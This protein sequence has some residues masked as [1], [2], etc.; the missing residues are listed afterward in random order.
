MATHSRNFF[1][2]YIAPFL[3]LLAMTSFLWFPGLRWYVTVGRHMDEV[4]QFIVADQSAQALALMHNLQR[5]HPHNARLLYLVAGI[6]MQMGRTFAAETVLY[7]YARAAADDSYER[8]SDRYTRAL[9]YIDS[10][11]ASHVKAAAD[12]T[13]GITRQEQSL[14]DAMTLLNKTIDLNNQSPPSWRKQVRDYKFADILS[15]PAVGPYDELGLIVPDKLFESGIVCSDHKKCISAY[16]NASLIDSVAADRLAIDASAIEPGCCAVSLDDPDLRP[17]DDIMA[18]AMVHHE[19]GNTR[20][21]NDEAATLS[22]TLG[23]YSRVALKH[24]FVAD[25]LKLAQ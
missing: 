3:M 16:G 9:H 25:F 2:N 8:Q 6:Y 13:L 20:G 1:G 23:I 15:A 12:P 7:A 10:F 5:E 18:E 4:N 22:R 21:K 14:S 11:Q 24:L 19:A 17:V